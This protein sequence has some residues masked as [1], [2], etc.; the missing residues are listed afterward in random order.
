M[1]LLPLCVGCSA[2]AAPSYGLRLCPQVIREVPVEVPVIVYQEIEKEVV[3]EIVREVPVEVIKEVEVIREVHVET[4]KEVPVY[5]DREVLVEV[6]VE[7]PIDV[8]RF[9]DR[10]VAVELVREVPV[11]VV[12]ET[13]QA[14]PDTH[15]DNFETKT[16]L[17]SERERGQRATNAD[18]LQAPAEEAVLRRKGGWTG[19]GAAPLQPSTAGNSKSSSSIYHGGG[20][21]GGGGG[22]EQ[23]QQSAR[24]RPASSAAMSRRSG[25]ASVGSIGSGVSSLNPGNAAA[26]GKPEQYAATKSGF[27]SGRNVWGGTSERRANQAIAAARAATNPYTSGVN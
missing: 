16:Y 7:V 8:E 11:E 13:Q 1:L 23:Q 22:Y 12:R 14:L 9:V 18:V 6:R 10:E 19:A 3:R 25:G 15:V 20:G 2:D 5:I 21:G 24:G 27:V 26:S 4:I 17:M